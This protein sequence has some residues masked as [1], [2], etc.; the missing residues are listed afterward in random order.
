MTCFESKKLFIINTEG[1]ATDFLFE[2]IEKEMEVVFIPD[3]LAAPKN[4]FLK[5]TRFLFV[6]KIPLPIWILRIWF[7]KEFLLSISKIRCDDHL[8]IFERINMRALGMIRNLLPKETK[9]YNWFGNPIYPLFKGKQPYKELSKIKKMGYELV[10]FDKEDAKQYSMTY[11]T[12]F[13]RFPKVQEEPILEVDFF[14]CGEP[15]DREPYLLWLKS[16]LEEV[17]YIVKY[18]IPHNECEFISYEEYLEYVK[19]CKCIIDIYQTGQSGL[20]RRPLEALFYNKKLLTNNPGIVEFDFYQKSNI[21][22]LQELN[23]DEIQKF[24]EQPNTPISDMVKKKYD[25]HCW[26]EKFMPNRTE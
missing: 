6:G 3:R 1:G 26:L 24:M 23:I 2:D 11:H 8:L 14:F 15:K 5:I 20:T 16:L 21:F 4:L 7:D 18:V 19:K 25:I 22:L 13:L 10:T 9:V 12:P 17:G